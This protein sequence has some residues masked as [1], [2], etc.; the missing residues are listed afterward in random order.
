MRAR[1]T[2]ASERS[3]SFCSRSAFSTPLQSPAKPYEI[4]SARRAAAPGDRFRRVSH[5]P[6]SGSARGASRLDHIASKAP[7][8]SLP[9]LVNGMKGGLSACTNAGPEMPVGRVNRN[10]R[11]LAMASGILGLPSGLSP[12]RFTTPPGCLLK[13][14]IIAEAA[15]PAPV[16]ERLAKRPPQ[17]DPNVFDRVMTVDV[18][19]ALCFDRNVDARMPCAAASRCSPSS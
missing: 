11:S 13:K 5:A 6:D 18:Q 15:N 17:H 19:I 8:G 2:A 10:W 1:F 3:I 14:L 7:P 4:A 16:A 9:V 12:P